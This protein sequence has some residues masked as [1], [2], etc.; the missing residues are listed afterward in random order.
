MRFLC[1]EC[2]RQ[3]EVL[4]DRKPLCLHCGVVMIAESGYFGLWMSPYIVLTR[5]AKIGETY[6]FEPAR[7]DGRFKREREAWTTGLFA[8]GLTKLNDEKWW[9]EI[10]TVENTPDTKLRQID[11]RSGRNVVLTRNIEVVDWEENVDDI[12]EVIKKKCKRAYPGDY[13][14]LVSARHTG[15]VLDFDKVIEEMKAIFSPFLE[16]WIVAPVGSDDVKL[17]RV[18]AHARVARII[19]SRDPDRWQR[20]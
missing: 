1:P 4:A 12:L 18:A 17:V 5:M 16:I 3:E 20:E 6:G 7:T 9:I 8:L 11:Q 14:L 10:E 2:A 13:I 19:G 15:K